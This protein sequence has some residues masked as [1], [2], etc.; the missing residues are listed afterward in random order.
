[1]QMR[2][3]VEEM[4]LGFPSPRLPRCRWVHRPRL[5]RNG[6]YK[7]GD[8]LLAKLL[9]PLASMIWLQRRGHNSSCCSLRRRV[10]A[11]LQPRLHSTQDTNGVELLFSERRRP[12]E[13][14]RYS[15]MGSGPW[16]PRSGGGA[17]A[18][19]SAAAVIA[20]GLRKATCRKC[21]CT[22][23]DDRRGG[24]G[25]AVL[26]SCTSSRT[27]SILAIGAAAAA[28]TAA[29]ATPPF[30]GGSITAVT[31]HSFIGQRTTE[32][33]EADLRTQSA[34]G[35]GSGGG[36]DSSSSG[37]TSADKQDS[38]SPLLMRLPGPCSNLGVTPGDNG[39]HIQQQ[40]E[41]TIRGRRQ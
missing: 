3:V 6:G 37:S 21:R 38:A 4:I 20:A 34:S 29:A 36:G 32:L 28:G 13:G 2:E 11:V 1:M 10:T 14:K 9:W 12:Q 23:R 18:P 7:D 17:Q 22:R 35:G 24:I 40:P 25:N 30:S 19:P 16:G 15:D 41:L 31:G 5:Q 8:G 26:Q 27:V 39:V 33:V